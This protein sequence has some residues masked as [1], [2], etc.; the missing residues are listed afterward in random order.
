MISI[1]KKIILIDPQKWKHWLLLAFL[2][3]LLF[4]LSV[5]HFS[6][7]TG[8]AGFWGGLRGDSNFYLLPFEN[9]LKNGIYSPD[10]KMPGYGVFY[11]PLILFFSKAV[12]CNIV[13]LLQLFLSTFSVYALALTAKNIFK[14]KN[15]FHITFF[16][17]LISTFS[18]LLDPVI[19]TESQT[20]STLILSV[21]FITVFF[22]NYK[23]KYLFI[24]GIFL[25]W[26]IFLRPAFLP[27]LA[28]FFLILLISLIR[29]RRSLLPAIIFAVPFV[30]VD[31]TWMER[32]YAAYRQVI[33]L[34]RTVL[35]P[36]IANSYLLS[37]TEFLQ[38]W[39]GDIHFENTNTEARWFVDKKICTFGEKKQ[40][41]TVPFPAY[42]YTSKFNADSIKLLKNM[43]TQFGLESKVSASQKAIYQSVIIAKLNLYTQSIKKEKPFLFY[44]KANLLRL[45][46]MLLFTSTVAKVYINNYITYY[47]NTF[48]YFSL[49]AGFL[50]IILLLPVVFKMSLQAIIPAIPL[51]TILVHSFILKQCENR[52]LIPA[53]PFII[54]SMAYGL[55]WGYNKLLSPRINLFKASR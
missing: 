50:G 40:T 11:F 9:L 46:T 19:L 4:F 33:P 22:N 20:A 3:R 28:F 37:I 52:F 49:L 39:Q 2:V 51:Y 31:G 34:T 1:I 43:I 44:V 55:I 15:I 29:S 24:S 32:N 38:A 7:Y 5:I 18:S 47:C 8:F 21:Y 27:L 10:V 35:F 41:D 12:A 53:Y 42:I 16:L 54:I 30:I 48:Y 45:K 14:I 6:Q 23:S 17:Y 26:A 13:I 25:T 36:W